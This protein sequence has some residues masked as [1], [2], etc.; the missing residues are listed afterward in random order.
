[1]HWFESHLDWISGSKD[2]ARSVGTYEHIADIAGPALHGENMREF[3]RGYFHAQ[4]DFSDFLGVGE[5]T[6]AGWMKN[7]SFPDYAKRAALAAYFANKHW[8]ELKAARKAAGRPQVVKDGNQYIV[9]RFKPDV[10]GVSVGEVLARDIPS[11]KAALVFASAILAWELIDEAEHVIFGLT[12][13]MDEPDWV[14]GLKERIGT[15]RARAFSHSALLQRKEE[16]QKLREEQEA[17]WAAM[18]PEERAASPD[19][20]SVDLFDG[21]SNTEEK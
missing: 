14:V 16:E 17:K 12:G 9:V 18:S 7:D 8:L 13:G 1:M 10:T 19:F 15:E 6:V 5:S 11:E 3:V 4:K 21:K 20:L 2:A